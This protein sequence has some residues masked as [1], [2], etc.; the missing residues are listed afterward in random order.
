MNTSFPGSHN[1]F[2]SCHLFDRGTTDLRFAPRQRH[3]W[4]M[5]T[6]WTLKILLKLPYVASLYIT[7]AHENML[8]CLITS[9]YYMWPL[10]VS[11]FIVYLYFPFDFFLYPPLSRYLCVFFPCRLHRSVLYVGEA[12]FFKIR[13]WIVQTLLE[14]H[15]I[16]I[17]HFLL[18]YDLKVTALMVVIQLIYLV[19]YKNRKQLKIIK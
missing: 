10:L 19:L 11:S 3:N 6:V 2:S 14:F 9:Y 15:W 1:I 17:T 5:L 12:L 7:S 16:S 13:A 4:M 18:V 8:I